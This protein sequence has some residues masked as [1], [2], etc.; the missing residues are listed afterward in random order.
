[1]RGLSSGRRHLLWVALAMATSAHAYDEHG[2]SESYSAFYSRAGGS[3]VSF[4]SKAEADRFVAWCRGKPSLYVEGGP[5]KCVCARAKQ[6]PELYKEPEYVQIYAD[7]SGS[8][9]K[10]D[11]DGEQPLLLFTSAPR[12][13]VWKK[14]KLMPNQEAL[15]K[16][17]I[18]KSVRDDDDKPVEIGKFS[19]HATATKFGT[20]KIAVMVPL[21]VAVDPEAMC[22]QTQHLALSIDGTAIGKYGIAYDF[23]GFVDLDGDE[24]PE[25]RSSNYCDGISVEVRDLK[26]FRIRADFTGH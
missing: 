24:I 26:D 16:E 9:V 25:I 10:K 2:Y 23:S 19:D 13:N 17:F 14:I 8:D 5:Q 15:V 12:P 20:D 11:E 18:A 21:K 3:V 4:G 7:C 1:M 6:S 22:E